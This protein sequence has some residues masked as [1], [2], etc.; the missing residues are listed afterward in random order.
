MSGVPPPF[1]QGT[2]K[3]LLG[4]LGRLRLHKMLETRHFYKRTGHGSKPSPPLEDLCRVTLGHEGMR[5]LHKVRKHESI[6]RKEE[7]STENTRK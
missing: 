7:E 6:R 5:R 2:E 1:N 3:S 4:S